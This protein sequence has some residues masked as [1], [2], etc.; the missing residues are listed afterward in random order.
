M[1]F[2]LEIENHVCLR[3]SGIS[4]AVIRLLVKYYTI[5]GRVTESR[6]IGV[7]ELKIQDMDHRPPN[8]GH[9]MLATYISMEWWKKCSRGEIFLAKLKKKFTISEEKKKKLA[10]FFC[11]LRMISNDFKSDF[12]T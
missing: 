7:I 6:K 9:R 8:V 1:E 3:R 2:S 11:F 12:T 10:I 4:F 5:D